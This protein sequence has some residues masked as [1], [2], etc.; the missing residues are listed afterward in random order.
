ML[1]VN[2]NDFP[3][4]PYISQRFAE[5]LTTMGPT[6]QLKVKGSFSEASALYTLG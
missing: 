1:T 6:V 4:F 3:T 5:V 2:G